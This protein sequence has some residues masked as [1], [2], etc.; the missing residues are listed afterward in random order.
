MPIAEEAVTDPHRR[1][2]ITGER[3]IGATDLRA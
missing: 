2:I 3:L 1:L